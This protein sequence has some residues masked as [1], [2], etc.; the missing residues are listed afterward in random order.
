[1]VGVVDRRSFFALCRTDP[2]PTAPPSA[3]CSLVVPAAMIYDLTKLSHLP[4]EDRYAAVRPA[5]ETV[6]EEEPDPSPNGTSGMTDNS[7]PAE[8]LSP[9]ATLV[10]AV[11]ARVG[12][13]VTVA[14]E[15][16]DNAVPGYSGLFD[17]ATTPAELRR[18]LEGLLASELSQPPVLEP[19][20]DTFVLYVDGSL[21]G[22]PGPAGAG[23]VIMDAAEDHLARLGHPVGPGRETTPPSTSPFNSDSLNC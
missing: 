15:A 8:H 18:A 2:N 10:D 9:L 7:L 16:I 1:M 3:P 5:D 13:E 6:L 21:R 17:L 4:S 23:A 20:G 22:N 14:T 19:T 11:L 12:Y